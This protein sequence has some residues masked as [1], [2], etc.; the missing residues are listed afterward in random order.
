MSNK[1]SSD[2]LKKKR[3]RDINEISTIK[4]KQK[5]IRDALDSISS[6]IK[7]KFNFKTIKF[8]A[9]YEIIKTFNFSNPKMDYF[10]IYL[11]KEEDICFLIFNLGNMKKIYYKYNMGLT[12]DI[13]DNKQLSEVIKEDDAFSIIENMDK[14]E[15][16]YVFKFT[17]T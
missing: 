3:K 5:E 14:F 7:L 8:V 12:I 1:E 16:F 10:F 15:Q 6:N 2:L 13:L 11:S 4:E 9:A 17:K